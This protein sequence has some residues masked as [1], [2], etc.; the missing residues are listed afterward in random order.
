MRSTVSGRP[1]EGVAKHRELDVAPDQGRREHAGGTVGVSRRGHRAPR[2]HG[3]GE[4]TQAAHAR[5][6]E[7]ERMTP[8]PVRTGADQDLVR[9][10]A[11]L[12]AGSEV[13]RPP[14]RKRQ[15]GVLGENLS[16]LDADPALD[17]E[18]PDRLADLEGR[19]QRPLRVVLVGQRDPEGSHHGVARKRLDG[20][21]VRLDAA[22][23]DLEELCHTAARDLRVRRGD[24][25]G[26][27]DEVDEDDRCELAFDHR[28]MRTEVRSPRFRLVRGSSRRP[29]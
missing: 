27:A 15:V 3:L 29:V 13:H 12:E 16:G 25:C 20:A 17:P 24:Q 21:A 5:R 2:G 6:L 18:L 23:D 14:C 28:S 1:L 9:L 4:P 10:G 26:R 7:L 22:R 19:A 8:E 11:L